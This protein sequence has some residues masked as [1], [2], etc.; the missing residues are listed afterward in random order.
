MMFGFTETFRELTIATRDACEYFIDLPESGVP[1]KIDFRFGAPRLGKIPFYLIRNGHSY[2]LGDLCDC[3]PPFEEMRE[4]ME[5]AMTVSSIGNYHTE[6]LNL[7]CSEHILTLWT[8]QSDWSLFPS[9]SGEKKLKPVSAL[10]I[11]QSGKSKPRMTLFCRTD[12]MIGNLYRALLKAL[13]EYS[14]QFN[15]PQNWMML[16]R[17]W[18]CTRKSKNTDLLKEQIYSPELECFLE[19]FSD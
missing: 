12:R 13:T 1:E 4:W 9:Q 3:Y 7:D 15:D 5:R 11:F 6:M 2:H 8:G 10:A 19:K 14:S 17:K 18:I 16:E